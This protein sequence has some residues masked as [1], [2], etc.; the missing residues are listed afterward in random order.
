MGEHMMTCA[1]QDIDHKLLWDNARIE[2]H[3][4]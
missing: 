2:D 4:P 1:G 3:K